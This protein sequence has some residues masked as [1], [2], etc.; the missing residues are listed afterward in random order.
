MDRKK[1]FAALLVLM[2]LTSAAL[3][4][5]HTANL[6]ELARSLRTPEEVARWMSEELTY[7]LKLPDEPRSPHQ[8]LLARCGDCDDFAKLASVIL[9]RMG[10]EN[11]IIVIRF[12]GLSVA[13]AICVWRENSGPYS[14]ISNRELQKTD[15][16][17]VEKLVRKFYPDYE[18]IE[19]V[20]TT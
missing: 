7:E 8:T 5:S 10:I 18:S 9:A 12:K 4:A 14:F 6:E 16:D 3:A 15:Q 11:E 19:S 20:K 17:S 2:S 13:H 1:V